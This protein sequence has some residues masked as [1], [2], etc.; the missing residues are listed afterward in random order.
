M[1]RAGT[2]QLPMGLRHKIYRLAAG[3]IGALWMLPGPAAA[4]TDT[5]NSKW[6][7][8]SANSTA[9]ENARGLISIPENNFGDLPAILLIGDCRG[10]KPFQKTW[11]HRLASLGY[12]SFLIDPAANKKTEADCQA[13]TLSGP[14]L[15]AAKTYLDKLTD[16]KIDQIAVVSWNY[17]LPTDLGGIRASISAAVSFY[18]TCSKAHHLRQSFPQLIFKTSHPSPNTCISAASMANVVGGEIHV[19][20][21]PDAKRRFD[22]PNA[23]VSNSI[24]VGEAA[25]NRAAHQDAIIRVETFLNTHLQVTLAQPYPSKAFS[26]LPPKLD[27]NDTPHITSG[28]G[29]WTHNPTEPGPNHPPLGQSVFDLVFSKPTETGAV[30][31]L[32]D[33]YQGVV[34]RLAQFVSNDRRGLAP[35]KQVLIPR[36]RSLQREAAKPNYYHDPRIVAAVDGEP[37]NQWQGRPIFLKDRLFLGYHETAQVLE[38]ISYNEDAARFEFQVVKNFGPGLKPKI[39]YADRQLCTSCHQN[40]AP[41][42]PREEWQETNGSIDT[43]DE[44]EKIMSSYH[45]VQ[46]ERSGEIPAAI[47]IATDRANLLPVL[48]RLWREGCGPQNDHASNKCRAFAFQAM[49]QYRLSNENSFDRDQPQFKSSYTDRL[50][51][52]WRRLWP[53]GLYISNSDIPDRNPTQDASIFGLR[54]PLTPRVPMEIWNGFKKSDLERMIVAMAEDIPSRDIQKLDAYIVNQHAS[55]PSNTSQLAAD[56]SFTRRLRRGLAFP[57]RIECRAEDIHF[58]GALTDW[59]AK[60]VSGEITEIQVAGFEIRDRETLVQNETSEK[61]TKS[62]TILLNDNHMRLPD[63]RRLSKLDLKLDQK[64][65]V[66]TATGKAFLTIQDDFK[67]VRQALARMTSTEF[68]NKPFHA[69]KMLSQLF[70]ALGVKHTN[71][72]CDADSPTPQPELDEALTSVESVD[73][74]KAQ[75]PEHIFGTYCARCHRTQNNVPPN[76]LYGSNQAVA[77]NIDHCAPRI[78]FRLSMWDVPVDER[79]RSPMPPESALP[80]FGLTKT[81][82]RNSEELA[83]LRKFVKTFMATERN[84]DVDYD[85]LENCLPENEQASTI[86]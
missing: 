60:H 2:G 23:G 26:P 46:V 31:D 75:S 1:T 20:T 62:F 39:L 8:L 44:L 21:Y 27:R 32:P 57:I 19:R 86:R 6:I 56:C 69:P 29:T 7:D 28:Y 63:G 14:L 47:D 34:R 51:T 22:D 13:G 42:F 84:S 12:V 49:L 4:D 58:I 30:Y 64:R 85:T 18:P 40:G 45:G 52:R 33:T 78:D 35:V 59:N 25:Y 43:N 77:N 82:W 72:C 65:L 41:L 79:T 11:A 74:L 38:V 68:V 50:T 15:T 16:I 81:Q 83:T 17:H 73:T 71:W 67:V 61:D 3:L 70:Q 53:N 48:Q 37:A 54:D 76:F 24:G 55:T 66:D 5:V 9:L 80:S 10:P 36:G